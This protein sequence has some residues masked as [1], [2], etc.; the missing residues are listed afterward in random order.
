MKKLNSNQLKRL[1][2]FCIA[3]AVLSLIVFIVL[4]WRRKL[5]FPAIPALLPIFIITVIMI[6]KRAKRKEESS[7]EE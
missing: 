5:E 2:N 3:L 6:S 1:Y 7:K 4:T